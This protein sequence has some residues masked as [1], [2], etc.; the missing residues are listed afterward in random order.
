MNTVTKTIGYGITGLACTFG[1]VKTADAH[2][3]GWEFF[4]GGIVGG[5]ITSL[6]C[7]RVVV[8]APT[9]GYVS[10]QPI[11][12]PQPL[13]LP[14]TQQKPALPEMQPGDTATLQKDGSW[15]IVRQPA[16][17]TSAITNAVQQVYTKQ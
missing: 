11:N 15:V 2:C 9:V 12:T 17:P 14:A 1:S 16:V 5:A 13:V 8:A 6:F 4:V 3:H 7:P 10:Y